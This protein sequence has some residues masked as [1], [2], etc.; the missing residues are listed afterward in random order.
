MLE[1]EP[2]LLAGVPGISL[3]KA[4][5]FSKEYRRQEGLKQ[6]VLL[7]ASCGVAPEYAVRVYRTFGDKAPDLVREN[8]YLLTAPGIGAPFGAADMLALTIFIDTITS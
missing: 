5:Q 1:K 7:L 8:P 3:K 6:L 2:R 4:E